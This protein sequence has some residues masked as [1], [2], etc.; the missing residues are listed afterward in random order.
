MKRRYLCCLAVFSEISEKV[1]ASCN[2]RE[3]RNSRIC[4]LRS[5]LSMSGILGRTT[6]FDIGS[7]LNDFRPTRT[8]LP[9]CVAHNC[10][11]AS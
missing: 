11:G 10:C 4:A 9:A 8:V 6:E 2:Y 7:R 3:W 5:T 1:R